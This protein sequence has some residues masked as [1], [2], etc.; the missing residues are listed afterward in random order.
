MFLEEENLRYYNGVWSS[1]GPKHINRISVALKFVK[2]GG[3]LEESR[4]K[5]APQRNHNEKG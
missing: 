2:G 3:N 4:S 5:K 1:K